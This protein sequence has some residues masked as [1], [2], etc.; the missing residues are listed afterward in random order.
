MKKISKLLFCLFCILS[1]DSSAQSSSV[2]EAS[3]FCKNETEP[4]I[5]S[6]KGFHINDVYKQTRH[7]FTPECVAE[8]KLK[9]KNAPKTSVSIHYTL[10]DEEYNLLKTRGVSGKASYLNLF[11]TSASK[12]QSYSS[13][14]YGRQERLVF[15]S[16]TDYGMYSYPGDLVLLSEPKN[17]IDQEKFDDFIQMYGTHYVSGLRREASIWVVLTKKTDRYENIVTDEN[18]VGGGFKTPFKVGVNF[19]VN[20][21]ANEKWLKNSKEFDLSIEV[22]GASLEQGT[23]KKNLLSILDD[24]RKADKVIAIQGL[25]SDALTNAANPEQSVISQYYFTPFT[26]YG[27]K[28]IN[29][30]QEKEGDLSRINEC[31]IEVMNA[32]SIVNKLVAPNGLQGIEEDFDVELSGFSKKE[33]YKSRINKTYSSILPNLKIY[34]KQLDTTILT[35]QRLYSKCSDVRCDAENGCCKYTNIENAVK[36]IDYKVN[37]EILKLTKLKDEAWAEAISEMLVPECEKENIGYLTV[38]NKSVNPYDFYQGDKF[39]QQLDGGSSIQFKVPPG[40]WEFKAVQVS[41]YALYA[42][43]NQRTVQIANACEESAIKVGFED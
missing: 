20:D 30:N 3:Y 43:I 12:Q 14:D 24:E 39:I 40:T 32:Q 31:V 11:S 10:T 33:V 22:N 35:L 18:S 23:L 42:T 5:E 27:V 38:I 2:F 7:C 28:N 6:G 9:A 37:A 13:E 1:V 17:L 19:Q 41:G 26:L 4:P 29:W 21:A 8:K 16:K 15:I 34:K 36:T 25:L